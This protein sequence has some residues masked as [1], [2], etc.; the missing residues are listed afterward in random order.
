MTQIIQ[1]ERFLYD[2]PNQL[3][4]IAT[5]NASLPQTKQ[6]LKLP[7]SCMRFLQTLLLQQETVARPATGTSTSATW[8]DLNTIATTAT[9]WH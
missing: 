3:F 7:S 8:A 5:S 2:D 4:Q 6:L 1:L 9:L